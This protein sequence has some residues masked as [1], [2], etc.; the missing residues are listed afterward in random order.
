MQQLAGGEGIVQLDEID[1]FGADAC[2]LAG[3]G[4]GGAGGAGSS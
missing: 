2:G 1:V 3:L 4:G